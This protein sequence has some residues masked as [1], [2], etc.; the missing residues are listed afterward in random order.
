MYAGMSIGTAAPSAEERSAVH[1]HLVGTK[2]PF[3]EVTAGMFVREAT[4]IIASMPPEVLPT[5]VGGAGLYISALCDGLSAEIAP[6]SDAAKRKAKAIVELHG[7]DRAWQELQTVD[8]VAAE[9]YMDRNPSRIQRALA[10]YFTTGKR[11][12]DSW[13]SK[14]NR[15]AIEP[16]RVGISMERDVLYHRINA[17][18]EA[19]LEQGLLAETKALLDAGIAPQ[20]QALQSVGYS[21]MTDLLLGCLT[22]QQALESMQQDSRR[23]AKRQLTWF[24]RDHR[25]TWFEHG[26]SLVSN[27]L[28]Y[29][30]P[31]ISPQFFR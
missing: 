10:Y 16:L 27:V 4:S 20:S 31:R 23:Y 11:I 22:Q 15:A 25:I 18:C 17:R 29:L 1:H 30:E 21:Q 14:P 12:S 7:R 24:R 28:E 9:T 5:V 8:S 13:Q 19:M 6:S 3:E 26:E 2:A